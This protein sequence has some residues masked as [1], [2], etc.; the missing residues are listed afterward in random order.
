MMSQWSVQLRLQEV[1]M[2]Q[3]ILV[4]KTLQIIWS[5]CNCRLDGCTDNIWW[6]RRVR[7]VGCQTVKEQI[8]WPYNIQRFVIG[9]D[10]SRMKLY[11]CEQ[12]AQEELIDS[13]LQDDDTPVFDRVRGAEK[14]H[15]FKVKRLDNGLHF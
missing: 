8:Q 9:I 11:D 5:S 6:T 1:V 13:A 14:F 12:E 4:L 3:L 10:R 15:D 2:G 7:P